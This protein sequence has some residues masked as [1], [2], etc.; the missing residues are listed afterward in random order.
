[1][2]Y[3]PD[4]TPYSYFAWEAD[5]YNV[6]WLDA[7]HPFPIGDVS[8]AC[9]ERLT[10]LTA[11]PV[12]QTFGFHTCPFCQHYQAEGE[13]RVA[14]VDKLYAA[15]VMIVHYMTIHRYCPPEEFLT[16]V[17]AIP[18][19]DGTIVTMPPR[20]VPPDPAFPYDDRTPRQV[21]IAYKHPTI[22]ADPRWYESAA[23]DPMAEVREKGKWGHKRCNQLIELL[24][25]PHYDREPNSPTTE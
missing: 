25:D 22:Y 19:V 2:P 10:L 17:L 9:S 7:R 18:F 24:A 23:D 12:H 21:A 16:A 13:I 5:T 15:P 8:H 3:Y 4:L 1:M 6:G 11:H 14:G 20:Y